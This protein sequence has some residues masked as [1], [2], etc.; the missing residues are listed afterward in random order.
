MGGDL[1]GGSEGRS[2]HTRPVEPARPSASQV[3]DD[4]SV[5]RVT[6]DQAETL[7]EGASRGDATTPVRSRRNPRPVPWDWI[8]IGA[9]D[10]T[11]RIEFIHGIVDGLHH[12]EVYEDHQHIRVT[13]F[14][15][16]DP[17]VRAGAYVALGLTAWTTATTTNPVGR[18]H[19]VDGAEQ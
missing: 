9:D 3:V 8:D 4:C 19:I 1:V 17:D 12:V 18:R 11:L 6:K 15:G 5:G 2:R 10:Q 16:L 7:L 13:V 14:V